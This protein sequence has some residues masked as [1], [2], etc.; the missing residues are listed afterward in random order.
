MDPTFRE[1]PRPSGDIFAGVRCSRAYHPRH[2]PFLDFLNPSTVCS[3]RQL[4]RHISYKRHL[5]DSKVKELSGFLPKRQGSLKK[6][7]LSAPAPRRAAGNHDLPARLPR[8]ELR[9]HCQRVTHLHSSPSE[10]SREEG[11]PTPA[12]LHTKHEPSGTCEIHSVARQERQ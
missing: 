10:K 2:L 3:S 11:A 12:L 6:N 1:L 8:D 9:R 4:A 5:W 7:L